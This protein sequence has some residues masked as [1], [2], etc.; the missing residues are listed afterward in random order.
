ML[1][2]TLAALAAGAIALLAVPVEMRFDVRRQATWQAS[3]RV[4]WMFGLLDLPI[5]GGIRADE[6]P[7]RKKRR[8]KSDGA[9]RLWRVILDAG[10]RRRLARFVRDALVVFRPCDLQLRCRLGLDDPADTGMLWAAAGPLTACTPVQLDIAP[11]FPGPAFEL[12]SRGRVR[13]I[14]AQV[15]GLV[16]AFALSPATVGAVVRHW[17]SA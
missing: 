8:R 11:V 12:M 4:R 15:L 10:F 5:T 6:K 9:A 14:P 1:L 2:W 7:A 3:V 17:R 13:I 16:A